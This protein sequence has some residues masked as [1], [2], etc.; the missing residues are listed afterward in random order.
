M[1]GSVK[2]IKIKIPGLKV[3]GTWIPGIAGTRTLLTGQAVSIKRI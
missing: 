1:K 2:E 3:L